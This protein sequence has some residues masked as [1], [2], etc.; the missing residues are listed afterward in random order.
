MT[1]L[2]ALW[3][4]QEFEVAVR[5][6]GEEV[7]VAATGEVDLLTAPHLSVV[8]TAVAARGPAVVILDLGAVTFMDAAG[9]RIIARGAEQLTRRGGRLV[10]RAPSRLVGRLLEIT[11]LEAVV[12]IEGPLESSH[13]LGIRP[14]PTTAVAPL[15]PGLAHH[16]RRVTAVPAGHD[17]I[18]GALRLM[19]AM[20]CLVVERADGASVSLNRRGRLTTVAATDPTVSSMDDDQYAVGEGPCV[21]ASKTGRQF[22]SG[23][24]QQETRWP[25]FVPNA[26]DLG[27]KAILSTPLVTGDRPVGAINMY[28]RTAPAFDARDLDLAEGVAAEVSR[29]LTHGGVGVSDDDVGERLD[30]ALRTRDVIAQAQGILM[31]RER[32]SA[33]Q[34]YA[35]LRRSSV[36]QNRTFAELAAELVASAA[37][38][39]GPETVSPGA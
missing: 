15:P 20:A 33:H 5:F 14:P 10:L 12:E 30:E 24:L 21:D 8:V 37:P 23:P 28:S 34:A 6:G 2:E 17:V 9:L 3:P 4:A 27:I 19:L 39:A 32:V 13:H 31:E 38:R 35:S 1:P 26:L 25:G 16:L 29:L 18:D 36:H 22:H 11:G 7:V